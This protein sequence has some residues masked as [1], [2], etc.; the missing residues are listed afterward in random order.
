MSQRHYLTWHRFESLTQAGT[1]LANAC[2]EFKEGRFFARA[3]GL[4]P[5]LFPI[6]AGARNTTSSL[7]EF[8]VPSLALLSPCPL[9][10]DHL[11]L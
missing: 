5:F 8:F 7:D 4:P 2:I 1:D 11:S 10:S 9:P 3:V 6:P